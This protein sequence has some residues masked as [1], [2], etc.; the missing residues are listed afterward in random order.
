M[1]GSESPI[2][3]LGGEVSEQDDFTLLQGKVEFPRQHF[4][5]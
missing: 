4:A 5:M 3:D 1:A 2:Y